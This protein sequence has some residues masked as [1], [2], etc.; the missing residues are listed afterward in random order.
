MTPSI[1]TFAILLLSISVAA[2]TST[3]VLAQSGGNSTSITGTVVDPSGAVVPN[4][5]VEVHN[6]VSQF[7]RSAVTDSKGNF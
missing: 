1:R 6:P 5:T 7:N 2:L 3:S 4:A